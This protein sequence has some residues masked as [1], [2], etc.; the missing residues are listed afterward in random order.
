MTPGVFSRCRTV[1]VVNADASSCS[2]TERP[3][4][5]SREATSTDTTRAFASARSSAPRT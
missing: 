1:S 5:M 3:E 2:W 4:G